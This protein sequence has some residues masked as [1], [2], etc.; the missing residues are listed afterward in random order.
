MSFSFKTPTGAGASIGR[1]DTLE[2]GDMESSGPMDAPRVVTP[3]SPR[4]RWGDWI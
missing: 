3:S 1:I 2:F 4:R